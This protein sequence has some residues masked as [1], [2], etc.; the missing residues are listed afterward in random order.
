MILDFSGSIYGGRKGHGQCAKVI[1]LGSISVDLY[2]S[3][4]VFSLFSFYLG[5]TIC[6][7]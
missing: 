4:F 5:S 7:S 6:T 2:L 3:I 1:S